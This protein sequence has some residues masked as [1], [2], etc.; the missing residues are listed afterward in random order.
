MTAEGQHQEPTLHL[1]VTDFPN[2]PGR[3]PANTGS[4]KWLTLPEGGH[5]KPDILGKLRIVGDDLLAGGPVEPA[6]LRACASAQ[7]PSVSQLKQDTPPR[8]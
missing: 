6:A 1:P 8:P 2:W 7:A 5:G 4:T 3:R